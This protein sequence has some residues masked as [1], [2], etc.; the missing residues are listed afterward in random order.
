IFIVTSIMMTTTHILIGAALSSRPRFQPYQIVLAWFGGFVPDLSIFIMVGYSRFVEV[1]PAGLWREPE[2]LY[3]Q[4]PWQFFSAVSNSFPMW[5]FLCALALF[6]FR[7]VA[8]LKTL[9]LALLIFSTAALSHITVDFFTH[10]RDAHVQF[11]PFSEWR[12]HSPISYYDPEFY[13]R[14]V[15]TLE[16]FLGLALITYLVKQ[17][18]NWPVRMVAILFGTPYIMSVWFIATGAM[19]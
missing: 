13:G 18:K 15:A 4:Q 14:I 16:I 7:R 3:W 1:G 19:H 12:F 9:G 5:I 17:F 2:G 11:W 10:A 6:L 8:A